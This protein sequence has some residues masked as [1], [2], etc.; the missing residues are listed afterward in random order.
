MQLRQKQL[1]KP[2]PCACK[3]P[4][5]KAIYSSWLRACSLT[6]WLK[7]SW[8]ITKWC[9]TGECKFQFDWNCF[10]MLTSVR[11]PG[12][13]AVINDLHF[14]HPYWTLPQETLEW[15]GMGCSF[16][17]WNSSLEFSFECQDWYLNTLVNIFLFYLVHLSNISGTFHMYNMVALIVIFL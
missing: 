9:F 12:K 15:G 4:D 16:S 7:A 14:V 5:R 13:T 3:T 11:I 8:P 1:L 2:W 17:S 6:P 10:E